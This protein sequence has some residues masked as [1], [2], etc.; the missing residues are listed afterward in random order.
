M[1]VLS[2]AANIAPAAAAGTRAEFQRP[3]VDRGRAI[4]AR[5]NFFLRHQPDCL[6]VPRSPTV[7][8][9]LPCI[10]GLSPLNAR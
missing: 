2:V 10:P 6:G 8:P 1:A 9:G 5:E 3:I 4:A 7:L